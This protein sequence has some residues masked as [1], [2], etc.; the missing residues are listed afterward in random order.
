[1]ASP[2]FP[3]QRVVKILW[4]S[5]NIS[6]RLRRSVAVVRVVSISNI[7]ISILI[8]GVEE[9]LNDVKM[10]RLAIAVLVLSVIIAGNSLTAFSLPRSLPFSLLGLYIYRK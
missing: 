6:E 4:S 9:S 8:T 2:L 5:V 3:E 7:V 10:M 1:V